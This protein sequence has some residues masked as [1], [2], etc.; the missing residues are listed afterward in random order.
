MEKKINFTTEKSESFKFREQWLEKGF[1]L[2]DITHLIEYKNGEHGWINSFNEPSEN[3]YHCQLWYRDECVCNFY[4]DNYSVI[5]DDKYC[6]F[7]EGEGFIFYRKVPIKKKK[8][9]G[10]KTLN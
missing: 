9:K 4:G 10:H 5:D 7:L 1:E 3:I 2:V 6:M 8:L